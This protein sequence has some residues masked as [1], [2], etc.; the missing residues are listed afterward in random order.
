MSSISPIRSSEIRSSSTISPELQSFIDKVNFCY[1]EYQQIRTLESRSK[2]FDALETVA[3]YIDLF[4]KA[5]SNSNFIQIAELVLQGKM[6]HVSRSILSPF[7]AE[8]V[9]RVADFENELPKFNFEKFKK[10]IDSHETFRKIYVPEFKKGTREL[11]QTTLFNFRKT[12]QLL[13]EVSNGD[14]KEATQRLIGAA[15][16]HLIS[17]P[18]QPIPELLQSEMEEINELRK[19]FQ[20]L[21]PAEKQLLSQKLKNESPETSEK[22]KVLS[23]KVWLLWDT[24][25]SQDTIVCKNIFQVLQSN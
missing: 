18:N 7:A 20:D 11:L 16:F 5:F 15:F 19:Q 4:P 14:K 9:A 24:I 10:V 23:G 8:Y 3:H 22:I 13:R 6:I 25:Y 2:Y 12:I 1:R 17:N 21:D